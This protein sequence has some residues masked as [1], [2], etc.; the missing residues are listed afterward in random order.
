MNNVPNR[1]TQ[2]TP[3]LLT[4]PHVSALIKPRDESQEN[5]LGKFCLAPVPA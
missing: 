3:G 2:V 5:Q 1:P 4:Q